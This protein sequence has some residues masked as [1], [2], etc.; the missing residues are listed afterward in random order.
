MHAACSRLL[1]RTGMPG[2]WLLPALA[3]SFLAT[4]AADANLIVNG[5]FEEGI[6][7]PAPGA[8]SEKFPINTDITGWTVVTTSGVLDSIDWVDSG[9]WLASDGQLSI[10]LSGQNAGSIETVFSTTIGVKYL[11]E[12]DLAG[13]FAGPDCCPPS[14]LIRSLRVA[15]AGAAPVFDFDV[16]GKNWT[17]PG[18]G[19]ALD[20]GWVQ[21]SLE[22][23][24]TDTT[25]TLRF[26][27]LEESAYGPVIDNVSVTVVPEPSTLVL[28]LFGL[29]AISSSRCRH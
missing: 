5:S 7:M 26:T 12:F 16:T 4:S 24:A 17:G 14:D 20:M 1:W 2:R 22:F 8:F 10:D 3:L 21:P 18:V 25:T 29:I 28:V 11:L 13:N 9:F 15:V 19:D 27:S 23:V 6:G